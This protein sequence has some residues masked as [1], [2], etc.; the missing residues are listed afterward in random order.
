MYQ[1]LILTINK[2]NEITPEA[3]IKLVDYQEMMIG[4]HRLQIELT[5]DYG[6]S[7]IQSTIT[8]RSS[9]LEVLTSNLKDV[10]KETRDLMLQ[11]ISVWDKEIGMYPA[12]NK[13]KMLPKKVREVSAEL[14]IM[15]HNYCFQSDNHY[16]AYLENDLELDRREI[17]HI[18]RE[19]KVKFNTNY[20]KAV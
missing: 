16:Q 20:P 18:K 7:Q 2:T 8:E 15:Y 4:S 9:I 17:A 11:T 12:S 13:F 14:Y 1:P 10:N 5:L 19:K 3:I 6:G